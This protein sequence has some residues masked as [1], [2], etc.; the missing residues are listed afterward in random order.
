MGDLLEPLKSFQLNYLYL[1]RLIPIRDICIEILKQKKNVEEIETYNYHYDMWE[2]HAG[3]YYECLDKDRT[4]RRERFIYSFILNDKKIVAERDRNM[5]YY[6]YT[7]IPYQVRGLVLNLISEYK[8]DNI[9]EEEIKLWRIEDDKKYC[10]IAKKIMEKS[11]VKRV[12][13]V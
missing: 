5:A 13:K 9:S 12:E 2:T 4:D 1:M 8:D 11:K 3:K 6:N 7:G 10:K